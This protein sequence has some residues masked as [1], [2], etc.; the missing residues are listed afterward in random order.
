MVVGLVLLVLLLAAWLVSLWMTGRVPR[1]YSVLDSTQTVRVG[2]EEQPISELAQIYQPL[3]HL[4]SSTPSPP[5]LWVWYE[6]IGSPETLDLV[7]FHVWADEIHPNGL[8][9]RL[10]RLFR[11]AY[12]GMPTYDVEFFQV[13][14]S[15]QDGEVQALTYE[16]SPADNFYPVVSEH[17]I[18]RVSRQSDGTF[19]LD[20]SNQAGERVAES[21]TV[22]V[23]FDGH[24]VQVGAQT[25]NHLTELLPG[26]G[27]DYDLL[28]KADLRPLSAR[29][30]QNNKF[31][32]KS[33]GTHRTE[34]NRALIWFAFLGL[35]AAV[36][37]GAWLVSFL[38]G[39]EAPDGRLR[40]G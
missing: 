36:L 40:D 1:A 27:S 28:L 5:L 12:Y 2:G 38:L 31:A 8:V 22:P 14:L 11:G 23:L 19:Q 18:A 4:R 3:M 9:D 7:Y 16:T 15:L 34:E 6:A 24:R 13:Q 17:L 20:L 39:R 21:R 25:W 26:P 33:Q 30:Y 10:Y 29:E 37:A 32:R 35:S